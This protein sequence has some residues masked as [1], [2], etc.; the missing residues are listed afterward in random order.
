MEENIQIS[1]KTRGHEKKRAAMEKKS[2]A[3]KKNALQ[4]EKIQQQ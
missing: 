2:P 4:W 3:M 1:R